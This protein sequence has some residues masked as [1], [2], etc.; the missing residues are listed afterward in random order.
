MEEEPAAAGESFIILVGG[1]APNMSEAQYQVYEGQGE[2]EE[3]IE[4]NQDDMTGKQFIQDEERRL[5]LQQQSRLPPLRSQTGTIMN[6][7]SGNSTTTTGELTR[8]SPLDNQD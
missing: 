2:N 3:L 7:L 6:T 4:M 1:M 8:G 5:Q